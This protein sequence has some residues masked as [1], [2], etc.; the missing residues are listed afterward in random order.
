MRQLTKLVLAGIVSIGLSG[1]GEDVSPS[2]T[3]PPVKESWHDVTSFTGKGNEDTS[4]F[5]L[6]GG[7]VKMIATTCCG[8]TNVGTYT[9]VDL[10]SENDRFIGSGL[11]ISTEGVEKGHG[12]T[13]Y[14]NI[15]KGDHYV[16][17]ISGVG[18]EVDVDEFY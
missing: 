7:K 14:R 6:R 17:V 4:S 11:S 8:S 13:I 5:Y 15:K 12:Q 18:W 2:K 3:S 16:S 1:C 9:A 10:E